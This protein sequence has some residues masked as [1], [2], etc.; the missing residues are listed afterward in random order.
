MR[1][2]GVGEQAEVGGVG[3]QRDQAGG[4][5]RRAGD[6]VDHLHVADVVDVET[7]LQADHKSLI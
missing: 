5:G 7:L 3:R 2:A 6:H 4:V 1:V